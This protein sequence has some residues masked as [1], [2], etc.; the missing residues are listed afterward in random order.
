MGLLDYFDPDSLRGRLKGLLG[1]MPITQMAQGLAEMP[2]R[3]GLLGALK[4]M[5]IGPDAEGAYEAAMSVGPMAIGATKK[6]FGNAASY[7]G[8]HKPSGRGSGAP[9]HDVTGGG[10]VYPDDFY[11]P[12]GLRYYGGY[13]VPGEAQDFYSILSARNRPNKEVTI[14]RAVPYEKTP[15]EK[16][17]DLEKQKAKY[18]ARRLLPSGI[19]LK[20]AVKWYEDVSKQ[21]EELKAAPPQDATVYQ[22]NPGDWVAL[23]REYAKSHGESALKGDY[24][25]VSKKVKAKD[26][27]T[28]GDS[29]QE[30][31]WWPE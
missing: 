3:A 15:A 23:S 29:F 16:L 25:I 6:V 11:G 24:K 4:G 26:I 14:Y 12:N 17:A 8:Q 13:G 30:W 27:F 20:D 18:M 19:D 10:T 1:G 31:G 9:L 22:I 21:I 28:S 7:Q 5:P 2:S